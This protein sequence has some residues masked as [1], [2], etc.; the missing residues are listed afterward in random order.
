MFDPRHLK[1]FLAVERER[2]FSAAARRLGIRQSTVSQHLA[3]LE[4]AVGRRLFLRDT[5]SVELTADGGAMVG[6][7]RAILDHH[8]QARRYFAESPISGR[9]RFGATEE[10]VLHEL[11][12]ILAEF[13]RGHP[14][15]ELHLTV[16]LNEELNRKLDDGDLDMVLGKRRPGQNRGEFVFRDRLVFLS[17]ADFVL[18]PDEPVPLVVYPS[19]SL[20]RDIALDVLRRDG[21]G[22]RITAVAEGLNGLRAAVL[23]GLGVVLHSGRFPPQGLEPVRSVARPLPD[24]GEVEFV[25]Q[26]RR[27]VLTAPERE[28]R[29]AIMADVERLGPRRPAPHP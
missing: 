21:R 27:S 16:A 3:K 25:L 24:A 18:E 29:A 22:S 19:P 8:E 20:T 10:L 1:S 23:A 17:S 9:L 2:N 13:R 7:A 28:L 6:F 12:S 4:Q 15:I 11:P 5:H 26:T 14:G